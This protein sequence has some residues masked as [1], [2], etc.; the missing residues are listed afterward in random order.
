MSQ[1]SSAKGKKKSSSLI[2]IMDENRKQTNYEEKSGFRHQEE[3]DDFNAFE[4]SRF[5]L[6]EA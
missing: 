2:R 1:L 5:N 6:G 4:E 3:M